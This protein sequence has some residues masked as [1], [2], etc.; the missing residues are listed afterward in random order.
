MKKYVLR[1]LRSGINNPIR[2]ESKIGVLALLFAIMVLPLS[3]NANV[4]NLPDATLT[5][6]TQKLITGVVTEE[7]GTSLPGV[8]IV[9]KGTTQGTVSDID[10]KFEISIPNESSILVFSFIGMLT[11]EITVSSQ[12]ELNIVMLADTKQMN[13]V[14]VTA[15]GIKRE[16]KA[17]GYAVQDVKADELTQTGNSDLVSSLSGKVA[18]VQINQSGGGVGGTSRIEI[19]GASSLSGNN[20]PLWVVDGVPFDDGNSRDGSVWGGTSRAGGAFDLNPEDIESISVL[21][22][23]NAAA[24]YGERGGNGVVLVTTKK[25]TR[26]K[27]LGISYSGS[28][29]FSEAAYML[30]LQNKYGQGTK[31]EYDNTN[32]SSWGPEMN[33][34]MFESWTGETIAYEAQKDRL[35]DFTR[36]GV[37]QKHNVSFTG[38]NDK[39]T[40][41]VS[42]GKDIMNGIYED[43][44]VEKTTFD[45]RADYDI[46]EWLNIDTKLSYFLTEGNERPEIGNYSYVSYFNSMPMNIRNQDL[47]PGYNIVG[48]KHVEKLYTTPNAGNRNP[49]FLQAQTT[50]HDEKNR[51]F[52]Y[53]AANIKLTS[54]LKA[55]FKYGMDFYQFSSLEGYLYADNVDASRPNYSPSQSN[56]K[57]ENY[58]FLLS[59]NKDINE[60]FTIGLN[61]GAN[62][63]NRYHKILN[64]TSGRL[65]SEGDFF[66]GAGSNI[67]ASEGITESEVRSIYGFGQIAYKNVLFLD[68]T[69]RNDWSSTLTAADAKFDN[70][71]FYPSFSLSGIVSEMVDLP[72]F[73][74]F[75][76]LRGS[77]AQVGKATTPYNTSQS[78]KIENW[79]FGLSR[80]MVASTQVIKDLKPEISTSWEVGADM[81]FL[82]NRIG[83]DFTYYN[84]ETKNQI[85]PAP[86]VQ[87]SGY[88]LRLIN[89]GLITNKGIELMLT[90]VP[91]K[92]NDFRLGIDFNFAKNEG[93]LE[94]LAPGIPEYDL[95]MGVMALPGEKLGVIRGSIYNRTESGE[96]I[97]DA[98]GLQTTAQGDDHIL[99]NIQADWTGSIN[100]NAEY[101]GFF[102]SALMSIQE[103]GDIISTS[104]QSAVSSGTAARTTENNR[105]ALFVDGV[106][107]DGGA[108]NVMISAE[109]YWRE[110]SKVDEE[111]I[112]D[113]SHMKLK[114]L[115]IG[116][117]IPKSIL[118][119][120]PHSPVKTARFSVVGRNLFY[121]YKHTPGTAPDASAYS[122]SLAAQAFD[123]SP[124][125]ATRTYGFSLNVG[126]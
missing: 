46:N 80:G 106:T 36:T 43:H 118:N 126:F 11:Q 119:K 102:L 58:E 60:D 39:G 71:Y 14:V 83:L 25:G 23:P 62:N 1:N 61:V 30:D 64:A 13:E 125:P 18:G 107:A 96:I 68:F 41:R 5:V 101:K 9:I 53:V 70:S 40:Y 24:L 73:I 93:I 22:G 44:K 15:L 74:T 85:L 100:L 78:F 48:G 31:G 17:L 38:G 56:F 10:G 109:E 54:D 63:M 84:E 115:A 120:I 105:M 33:G 72:E 8:S 87:S 124:V 111:F 112:Y 75:T 104:E 37:A 69:A 91:V 97:V 66:L 26:G 42:L 20:A 114:E 52:G 35:K 67:K 121:F 95:G 32:T 113:A 86:T 116:Y 2:L 29:T 88:D 57:E 108:N 51:T 3:V 27:G 110:L 81:R 59:Y 12:S 50:N 65:S 19:R 16:K 82:N 76:K 94:K 28:F 92:T 34:Q 90:T 47:A 117:N 103:G 89:A 79:N 6:A 7:N 55:K 49:Y 77:W 21:K 98:N 123:F 122:S 4:T 45:L 99:G